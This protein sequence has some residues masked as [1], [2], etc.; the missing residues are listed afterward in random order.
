MAIERKYFIHASLPESHDCVSN[1]V[2][3]NN[4][5]LKHTTLSHQSTFHVELFGV[6][7]ANTSADRRPL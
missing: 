2:L 3:F 6:V 5:F 4:Y 1:S 7:T